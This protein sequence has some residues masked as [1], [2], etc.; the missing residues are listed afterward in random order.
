MTSLDVVF[1]ENNTRIAQQSATAA[2]TVATRLR[3]GQGVR[4]ALL[5]RENE[6][7][8]NPARRDAL[9][10]ERLQALRAELAQHGIRLARCRCC[11]AHARR[12]HRAPLRRGLPPAARLQVKP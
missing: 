10:D 4:M 11:G 5:A 2:E 12:H 3:A 7:D 8:Q 6:N 9:T 1:E